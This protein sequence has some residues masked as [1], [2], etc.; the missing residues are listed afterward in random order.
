MPAD[1]KPLP[2]PTDMSF[3]GL[4][5]PFS[6]TMNG[7]LEEENKRLRADLDW[8]LR[9]I[10]ELRKW[11]D[12]TDNRMKSIMTYINIRMDAIEKMIKQMN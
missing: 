6:E 12:E 4:P 3:D 10:K 11:G 9:K 7:I 8:A 2:N 1:T 5:H